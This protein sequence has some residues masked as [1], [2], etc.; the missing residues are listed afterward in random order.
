MSSTVSP[1][2][3]LC[4]Y[5]INISTGWYDKQPQRIA[6][7]K[8][9]ER[10]KVEKTQD[11]RILSNG[12]NEIITGG[13]RQKKRTFFSG[14]VQLDAPGWYAGN[15]YE[16]RNGKKSISLVLFQFTGNDQFLSVYYFT[17]WYKEN[18]AERAQFSNQFAR[19]MKY[20][21]NEERGC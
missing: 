12:A 15:D 14:L 21:V 11:P 13:F 17:G 4:Q 5:A 7:G 19:T 3:Q 18:R 20:A 2:F 6:F 9:P 1:K 16:V 10:L 8:L